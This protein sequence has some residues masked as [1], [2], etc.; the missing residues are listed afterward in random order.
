MNN[1]QSLSH[2]LLSPGHN[3]RKTFAADRME[4]LQASIWRHGVRRNLEAMEDPEKKGR[5]KLVSG[6]RR[7]RATDEILKA[8][9][10]AIAA[11]KDD[12]PIPFMGGA[13]TRAELEQ[14]VQERSQLPVLLLTSDE[15][16][17]S[18]ELSLVENLQSEGLTAA[19]EARG[20]KEL[21][22]TINPDTGK[23]F[24]LEQIAFEVSE[25]PNYVRRRIQLLRAPVFLLDAVQAKKIGATIAERVGRIPDPKARELA[26]N[27]ILNPKDQEAPLTTEQAV[28]WISAHYMVS[29]K[30]GC[31]FDTHDAQL[32]PVLTDAAGARLSGG[33]CDDCPFRSGNIADIQDDLMTRGGA[34]D[35][36][37]GGQK[38]GIDTNLCTHPGC[39][40]LKIDAHWKQVKAK[41]MDEIRK[42]ADA[43]TNP[44]EKTK[45]VE[46][47]AD[48]YIIDGDKAKKVFG[49]YQGELSYDSIYDVASDKP[50][51]HIVNYLDDKKLPTWRQLATEVGVPVI[52]ARNPHTNKQES[53]VE[54]DVV[55]EKVKAAAKAKGEKCIF[56]RQTS[57]SSSGGTQDDYIKKAREKAKLD[58][59]KAH[60]GFDALSD[61]IGKKGLDADGWEIVFGMALDHA[62]CDGQYF[63]GKWLGLE[64]TKDKKNFGGSGRDYGPSILAHVKTLCTDHAMQWQQW[65]VLAMLASH[66]K[67]AGIGGQDFKA[68]AKYYKLDTTK[69]E[70][71][72]KAKLKEKGKKKTG[73]PG[74]KETGSGKQPEK[75]SVGQLAGVKVIM[76]GGTLDLSGDQK[77][78]RSL[79]VKPAAKKAASKPKAKAAAPA[80]KAASKPAAPAKKKAAVK[81]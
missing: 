30:K 62:G 52:L 60:L 20:Y 48:R 38:A 35:G 54:T 23:L 12:G 42:Q 22:E 7:W 61:A 79:L 31:D 47:L 32:V 4:R 34:D 28:E 46:A 13:F 81:K 24:T 18:R 27:E 36:K 65:T 51:G 66:A 29:L 59:A 33:A 74:D 40:R 58:T 76:A 15:A 10:A 50:S 75:I 68:L 1:I 53:L 55:I 69:L 77:G 26:A 49:G 56:D 5:F 8:A 19:E 44:K 72:A 43:E 67:Y 63:L 9:R 6:E 70:T 11:V 3:Y 21:T 41:K 17:H 45:M 25:E 37:K 78:K 71:E 57:S 2:D 73:R 39:F 80:K 16:K 64:K 14:R